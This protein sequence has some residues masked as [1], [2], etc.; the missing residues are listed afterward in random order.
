MI[1]ILLRLLQNVPM[2][3][4]GAIEHFLEQKLPIHYSDYDM[5]L[6]SQMQLSRKTNFQVVAKFLELKIPVSPLLNFS[7]SEIMVLV[8]RLTEADL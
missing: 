6:Y 7:V 8:E 5:E 4:R 1:K 3:A 2:D